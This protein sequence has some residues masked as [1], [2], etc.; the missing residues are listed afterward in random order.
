MLCECPLKN[1]RD[2]ERKSKYFN[3]VKTLT[4]SKAKSQNL[5]G[6]FNWKQKDIVSQFFI[7]GHF[8]DD[9]YTIYIL[10][11]FFTLNKN[12]NLHNNSSKYETLIKL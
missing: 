9:T 7:I 4:K 1:Q 11:I 3:I 6:D 10:N 12:D 2:K 8:M 5:F